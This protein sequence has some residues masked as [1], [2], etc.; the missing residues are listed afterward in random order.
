MFLCIC[1]VA[2]VF[3]RPFDSPDAVPCIKY[4]QFWWC[5]LLTKEFTL[6]SIV[7]MCLGRRKPLFHLFQCRSTMQF[8][9]CKEKNIAHWA[10]RQKITIF[11]C[12]FQV[13]K[14][15]SLMWTKISIVLRRVW[16]ACEP[17]IWNCFFLFYFISVRLE[18]VQ[19]HFNYKLWS[20][21][22]AACRCEII[23]KSSFSGISYYVFFE[24]S[25]WSFN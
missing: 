22:T 6:F 20:L 1:C 17:A 5:W 2:L 7:Y 23:A 18:Q 9:L 16:V 10:I 8:I 24:W 14:D 4:A 19:G 15:G 25:K 12:F 3:M 13:I 11:A 21:G